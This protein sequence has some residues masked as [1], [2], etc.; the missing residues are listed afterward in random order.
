MML[1]KKYLV[2][3]CAVAC[4][5]HIYTQATPT[6][7]VEESS[8]R[9]IAHIYLEG[10]TLVDTQAILNKIPYR[11]G[12]SFDPAHTGALLRSLYALGF[13]RHIELQG[14]TLPGHQLDIYIVF[15]EKKRLAGVRF[16][17]N[18]QVTEDEIKK[19]I[20]FSR[21]PAID[22]EE[23]QKY[24]SIIKNMYLEKNYHFVTIKT[25][26][27]PTENAVTAVF[28]ITEDVPSV[29]K[30]ILFKGNTHI[31]SKRLR[32]LLFSRED[33]VLGFLDSAGTYH[34]DA[35]DMD[36]YALETFYQNQGY[37]EAKI[38][39]VD[40]AMDAASKN[41]TITFHI[42]EGELYHISDV[43]IPGNE[44]K[45]EEELLKSLPLRTGDLY[46]K[47]KIQKSLEA[48]RVLWGEYGYIYADVEPVIQPDTDKKT[49]SIALYSELGNKVRLNRINV[50]G[51]KKS[52]DG[53]IRRQ[54]LL[55]EGEPLTTRKMDLSKNRVE[56]LG[57]FDKRDG[58]NWKINRLADDLA[59]LDL[60]LKEVRTGQFNFQL[61]FGG[62]PDDLTNPIHTLRTTFG[63]SDKNFRGYGIGYDLSAVLARGEQSG[64]LNLINPYMFNRPLSG[65]LNLVA[66]NVQYEDLRGVVRPIVERRI[67]GNA[68][69][70]FFAAYPVETG[71][72]VQAGAEN[73]SYGAKPIS[74]AMI[75]PQATLEYQGILDHRFQAGV[76]SWMLAG[77]NHD[78][79]N[80][81]MH[82]TRGHQ[83]TIY[84][85]LGMGF[86]NITERAMR[87]GLDSF[88]FF[89][90]DGDISWYTPLI[91]EQDLI[92][93]LHGHFGWVQPLGNHTVPYRELYHIGGP[94]TV[95]GFFFGQI[96]P[97]WFESFERGFRDSIGGTKAFWINA[98]LIFPVRPDFS[99]KGAVFYDGGAGWDTPDSDQI[100]QSR[101]RNNSFNYRH[102]VGVGIRMM[103]PMP[104]QIDWGFKLDRNK[105]LGETESEMHLTMI[106]TF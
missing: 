5:P 45:S 25:K 49:V 23:L 53:L 81:P 24:V 47:V 71:V 44:I 19:K 62:A 79:R 69:L 16:E 55:E 29:I 57:Y 96:S 76:L 73:L 52:R 92:F 13:F 106:K 65:A 99:I 27:E 15:T 1:V 95:R 37:L 86:Q 18:K 33:W 8:P 74:R 60:I 82:P 75:T 63:I 32:S 50:V 42:Q 103:Q 102:A 104:V 77:L 6:D 43:S 12:Q 89:K 14:K 61:G 90:F 38:S 31:N 3:A 54:I 98:E 28:T 78:V 64:H 17:G 58:V 7:E 83:W 21:I 51:N 20:D 66:S 94:A 84:S 80:H 85:K 30:R 100:N 48:L 11:P 2:I 22:E 70:G 101:L 39:H 41:F 46:S 97:T 88:G 34:P 68:S 56:L 87:Q 67:G 105:R 91:G 93:C 40:V 59:D 10:N 36:K 9:S 72:Q 26:L 4:M 35:V